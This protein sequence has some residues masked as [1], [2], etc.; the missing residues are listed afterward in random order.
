MQI[1]DSHTPSNSIDNRFHICHGERSRPLPR[2]QTT[3]HTAPSAR[4]RHISSPP[5]NPNRSTRDDGAGF[6]GPNRSPDDALPVHGDD[7]EAL[8]PRHESVADAVDPTEEAARADSVV[9]VERD[10]AVAGELGAGCVAELAARPEEGEA[11]VA[12]SEGRE[13]RAR[14]F[15][16]GFLGEDGLVDQKADFCREVEE[17]EDFIVGLRTFR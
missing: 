1:A 7:V 4:R 8:Q 5:E 3:Q 17:G 9:A 13:E 2:I 15:H 11:V 16:S 12:G 10:G 6:R 14:G